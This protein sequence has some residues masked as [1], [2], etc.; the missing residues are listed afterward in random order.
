M[1]IRVPPKPTQEK[2][3]CCLKCGLDFYD[4]KHARKVGVWCPHISLVFKKG[5]YLLERGE[6][7]DL[8]IYASRRKTKSRIQEALAL[9][10]GWKVLERKLKANKTPTKAIRVIRRIYLGV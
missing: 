4:T 5:Q 9:L 3:A 6:P 7:K 1:E 8:G 10:A 2:F